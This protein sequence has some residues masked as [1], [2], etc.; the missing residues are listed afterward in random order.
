MQN[1]SFT[2]ADGSKIKYMELVTNEINFADGKDEGE[3]RSPGKKHRK[4]KCDGKS[5]NGK[6]E[7]G[8]AQEE[9]VGTDKDKAADQKFEAM[10]EEDEDLPFH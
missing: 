9:T 7:C 3:K 10:P 1:E 8:P 4:R 6:N 5:R 2:A